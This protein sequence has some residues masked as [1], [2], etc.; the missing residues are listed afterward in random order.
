[1]ENEDLLDD[2][3]QRMRTPAAQALYKLRSRTVELS[4]ADLKEHRGLRR[5]HARGQRRTRAEV[6]S[7]I[8]THNLLHVSGYRDQGETREMPNF[9]K[10]RALRR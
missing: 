5:F 10:L 2:L 4:F 3:R 1:M 7:L 8:L 9:A 6:G